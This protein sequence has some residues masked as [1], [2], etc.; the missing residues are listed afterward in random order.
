MRNALA[1]VSTMIGAEPSAGMVFEAS[2]T[3]GLAI[4]GAFL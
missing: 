3:G 2:V 4:G 1:S